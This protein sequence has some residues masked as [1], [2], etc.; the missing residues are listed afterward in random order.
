MSAVEAGRSDCHQSWLQHLSLAIASPFLLSPLLRR[1]ANFS[2]RFGGSG[3]QGRW[4]GTARCQ[5]ILASLVGDNIAILPS[6]LN[7]RLTNF[8]LGLSPMDFNN[9]FFL[10]TISPTPLPSFHITY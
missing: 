3:G 9:I 5:S 2:Y 6:P 4:E 1:L 7:I 8:S 10:A